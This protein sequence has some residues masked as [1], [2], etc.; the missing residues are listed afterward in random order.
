MK[1]FKNILFIA[2]GEDGLQVTFE[3]R[4]HRGGGSDRAGDPRQSGCTRPY[5][6]EL[7]R[8]RAARNADGHTAVKPSGF[9]SPVVQ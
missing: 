4:R 3:L 9:V 1:H 2:D 6:R 8:R 5:H 7:G